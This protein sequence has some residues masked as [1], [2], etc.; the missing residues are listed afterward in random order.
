MTGNSESRNLQLC[1]DITMPPQFISFFFIFIVASTVYGYHRGE[2]VTN[3][4][5]AKENATYDFF[6]AHKTL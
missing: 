5:E 2:T 4:A 1:D 6:Y 3:L